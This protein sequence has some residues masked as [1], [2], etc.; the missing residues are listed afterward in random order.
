[1]QRHDLARL[2]AL[3]R[4]ARRWL[5]ESAEDRKNEDEGTMRKQTTRY[6]VWICPVC[7][8]PIEGTLDVVLALAHDHVCPPGYTECVGGTTPW[9]P[10]LPDPDNGKPIET[11]SI[12]PGTE[13][14]CA[15][16][17]CP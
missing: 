14:V 13:D 10:D 6:S 9:M 5:H 17:C 11:I 1:M 4:Q 3:W 2:P 15:S 16:R 7:R 8:Q 12:M